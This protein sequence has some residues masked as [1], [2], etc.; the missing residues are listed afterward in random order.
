MKIE[1]E[2]A[3]D[4]SE[5]GRGVTEESLCSQIKLRLESSAT[6]IVEACRLVL[7]LIDEHG[8]TPEE[9]A[10]KC[11]IPPLFIRN[12]QRVGRQRLAPELVW[13]ETMA[14]RRLARLPLPEQERLLRNPVLVITASGDELLCGV[15][16]LTPELCRQVFSGNK[17][18][19]VPEQRVWLETEARRH[20]EEKKATGDYEVVGK[21][22]VV[23]VGCKF[24]A[25]QLARVLAEMT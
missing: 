5:R 7:V 10:T 17:L 1:Q 15:D 9:I 13:G 24:T 6:E 16:N 11:E 2:Q 23:H 19:T 21:V 4:K 12:L 14:K 8:W 18:R 3:L 20:K 22:L 25:S